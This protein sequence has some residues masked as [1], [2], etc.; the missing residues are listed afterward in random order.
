MYNFFIA[1]WSKT[2]STQPTEHRKF[3]LT[4]KKSRYDGAE[5]SGQKALREN[6]YSM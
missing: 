4:L 6:T 5:T 2:I 3:N 1:F